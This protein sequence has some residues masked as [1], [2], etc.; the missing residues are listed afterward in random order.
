MGQMALFGAQSLRILR[1]TSV[2]RTNM[3]GRFFGKV[4]GFTGF[5]IQYGCI[6]HCTFEYLGEIVVC[7][8]PSMEPT[9]KSY[10]VII[11]EKLSRQF[12]R[13]EKGD[14]IIAK[15]PNDPKMNICKRVIGLEGD[16][17][18]TSGPLDAFKSHRYMKD[19]THPDLKKNLFGIL[20]Q[21]TADAGI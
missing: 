19:C 20:K 8:G 11:S 9:I 14:V 7:S 12:Y 21:R 2:K 10:D 6:A 16:K 4:L 18:S 17:V 1:L 15:S 5:T 13:I 3:L